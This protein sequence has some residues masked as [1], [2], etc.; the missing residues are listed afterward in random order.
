MKYDRALLEK[1]VEIYPKGPGRNFVLSSKLGQKQISNA[2]KHI[3]KFIKPE[4]VVAFLDNTLFS[5]GKEGIL[6]TLEKVASSDSI[7]STAY[8]EKF[9]RAEASVNE[10]IVYYADNARRR[11]KIKTYAKETASLLN[12]IVKLRDE[13]K[14]TEPAKAKT[15]MVEEIKP[16]PQEKERK[17]EAPAADNVLQEEINRRFSSLIKLI[18]EKEEADKLLEASVPDKKDTEPVENVEKLQKSAEAGEPEAMYKLGVL[19]ESGKNGGRD[20]DKAIFWL[21]KAKEKGFTKGNALLEKLYKGKDEIEIRELA[22]KL[23][24]ERRDRDEYSFCFEK[25]AEG[26]SGFMLQLAD[27]CEK[28]GKDTYSE[29]S[30]KEAFFWTALAAED[31]NYMAMKKLGEMFAEGTGV[32]MHFGKA[33]EWYKKTPFAK[34]ECELMENDVKN[35]I[36]DLVPDPDW[37]EEFVDECAFEGEGRYE[38][39]FS[40]DE[41]FIGLI[42]LFLAAEFD[43][44]QS[45]YYIGKIYY[46]GFIFIKPNIAKAKYWLEKAMNN[47][48]DDATE[49]I[50]INNISFN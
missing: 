12:T 28:I 39:S 11:I 35:G 24:E 2:I 44:P 13:A 8:F 15:V 23:D 42:N 27:I 16:A 31:G 25:A 26:D 47:G 18:Q 1:A 36:L 7:N 19:F 40:F 20:V 30:F 14:K 49:Y 10:L 3:D 17:T 33:I 43:E 32:P 6:I 50:R 5:N 45:Q 38:L 4:E 34:Y 37:I 48:C 9:I 29:E 22:R 21:E 41:K 46:E